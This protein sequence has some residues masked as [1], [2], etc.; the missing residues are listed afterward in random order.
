MTETAQPI[1]VEEAKTIARADLDAQLDDLLCRWHEWC[2][3]ATV[4][5]GH[6]N[7]SLVAGDY[8]T[9]RQYDDQNGA[10]DDELEVRTCKAVD[11]AVQGLTEMWRFAIHTE[12]R[13]LAAGYEVFVNPRLPADLTERKFVTRAARLALVQRLRD[14]GVI[15]KVWTC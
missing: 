3:H 8:L 1:S 2:S 6:A 5:R 14:A 7:H 9:S 12:A 15:E 4:V 13:N 10:L 11:F